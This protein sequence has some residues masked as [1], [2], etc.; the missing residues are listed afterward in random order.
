MASGKGEEGLVQLAMKS[1]GKDQGG[2][3]TA[4]ADL[5]SCLQWTWLCWRDWTEAT[6]CAWPQRGYAQDTSLCL[7]RLDARHS[8]RCPA[9]KAERRTT[10]ATAGFF[11]APGQVRLTSSCSLVFSNTPNYRAQKG[12]TQG[13][14]PVHYTSVLPS[15]A[16][17]SQ[18]R[19]CMPAASSKSGK[20]RFRLA[21]S[22][23]LAKASVPPQTQQDSLR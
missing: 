2:G 12:F 11:A 4:P 3:C 8:W 14:K 17:Q 1:G 15:P 13:A 18:T 23:P 6:L 22:L 10:A 9:A 7:Y 20:L 21:L 16:W 19:T 5:V